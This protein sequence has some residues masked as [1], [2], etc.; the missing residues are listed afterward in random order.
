MSGERRLRILGLLG[1]MAICAI[2]IIASQACA[3]EG[4]EGE[5][6]SDTLLYQLN[7]NQNPN[8]SWDDDLNNT[9]IAFVANCDIGVA[10]GS[11][12]YRWDCCDLVT[13]DAMEYTTKTYSSDAP[14]ETKALIITPRYEARESPDSNEFVKLQDEV[15]EDLLEDQDPDGSWN[16]DVGDTAMATWALAGDEEHSEAVEKGV[17]WLLEQENEEHSWGSVEDDAKAIL[18]LDS[19]G[20]DVWDEL[21]TLMLKQRP[22]GSFGGIEDTAWA[23]MALS[24]HP[25]KENIASMER[26]VT[27]L[28]AQ[29]Y[30]NNR[31]LALAAMA[32]QSYEN[33][34]PQ[35]DDDGGESGFIPPPWLYILSILIISSLVLSYWLF[36][37]LDRDMELEGVRKELYTYI[38]EHPGEHLAN[39]TKKLNLG[40]SS[41]RYHLSVLEGMD[42]IVCHKNGKYKRYYVNK[43]GYS[44]YTNGNGYKHIMSAL[45]NGTARKIV[46]FLLSNPESNQKNVSESLKIHPST[47]NWHAERLK[48]AEIIKKHKKGKEIVYSLNQDVQLR[49][50]I[51]II[52]GSPA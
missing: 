46:K 17:D 33:V 37:R 52:E 45:K 48:D 34:K 20:L 30:D 42:K 4:E 43:N 51:G 23:V 9:V 11:Y 44:K 39:I 27:W 35:E 25:N 6:E 36:A 38:T 7:D 31:D 40:S 22:D 12:R 14:V 24:T 28:R 47:V 3:D 32:E 50:V 15:E 19:A 49:K 41:A 8:G 16:E 21:A 29:D 1:L 10:G 5:D 18:A 26:A 13:Y 2:F